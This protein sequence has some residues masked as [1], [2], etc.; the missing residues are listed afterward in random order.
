MTP[1]ETEKRLK[2]KIKGDAAHTI[3]LPQSDAVIPDQISGD[4]VSEWD[5][6]EG[7]RQPSHAGRHEHRDS[8]VQ[9]F[10]GPDPQL[11]EAPPF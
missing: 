3:L 6:V 5:T 7:P 9:G 8:D 10:S 1:T 11:P 2:E 4:C